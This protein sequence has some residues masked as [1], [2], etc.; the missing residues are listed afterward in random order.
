MTLRGCLLRAPPNDVAARPCRGRGVRIFELVR[1]QGRDGSLL[2]GPV[3]IGIGRRLDVRD[4]HLASLVDG[5]STVIGDR[6]L[7][8]RFVFIR[9]PLIDAV[10][11]KFGD[12]GAR[13]EKRE[14]ATGIEHYESLRIWYKPV[15]L[16]Y[17]FVG[18]Y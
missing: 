7:Q 3:E 14:A 8:H 2:R 6:S 16:C 11:S 15:G 9:C 12:V 18:V 4:Q 17:I 5:P 13:Y 1:R 10:G